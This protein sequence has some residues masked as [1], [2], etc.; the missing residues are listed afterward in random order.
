MCIWRVFE[1]LALKWRR[2]AAATTAFAPQGLRGAVIVLDYP[3]V[4][5][6][7]N[8]LLAAV[9]AAGRTEIVNAAMEPEIVCLA[10]MLKAMGARI[11]GAGQH[12]IVID[13]VERLS[14]VDHELIADRIEAGTLA[15]AAVISG[16]D[17]RLGRIEPRHLD[18]LCAK[19]SEI[20]AELECERDDLRVRALHP[21]Q[22]TNVQAL[23]YSGLCDRPASADY[24]S[25]D[26]GARDLDRA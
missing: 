15:I 10:E 20:G 21:L 24:R 6:T 3:S 11:S 13:G 26:A 7:E 23:P 17:V 8:L 4:L 16:G 2:P 22:A 14:G 9:L 12:T 19:L 18:A 5:G 1:R 25:A